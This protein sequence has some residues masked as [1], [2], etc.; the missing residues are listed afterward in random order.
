[1]GIK[2]INKLLKNRCKNGITE[3][4]ISKFANQIIFIDTSI[5]MYRYKHSGNLENNFLQLINKL[6]QFN[7]K[8]V[9]IFDGKPQDNK[10]VIQE[11]KSKREKANNK[12]IK[13]QEELLEEANKSGIIIVDN[14]PDTT[15]ID[16]DDL[17]ENLQ[18]IMDKIKRVQKNNIVVTYND[19]CNVK[20][21]LYSMNITFIQGK[22]ETDLI[23][24]YLTRKYKMKPLCLSYDT[25]FLAHGVNLL[26]K[27]DNR[28]GFIEYYDIDI[29]KKELGINTQEFIDM[30]VLMGCDYCK[31]LK[32]I[33]PMT[34]YKL[35]KKYKTLN[36]YFKSIDKKDIE[37]YIKARDT[38]INPGEL[39]IE[40]PDIE[41]K[42]INKNEFKEVCEELNINERVRNNVIKTTGNKYNPITKYF[43]V[44]K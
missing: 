10:I 37:Q 24:P 42:Q 3:I 8:P 4:S 41:I 5:F 6:L 11:R 1:M 32:G 26:S 28:S 22:C 35:I 19:F 21:I 16:E 15:N 14:I 25:D 2:N 31:S 12:V 39:E 30:C 20:K 38:F 27:F 17:P 43:K 18:I 36:N 34:A 9:F 33:G 29:I 23:V 7:I 40:L 44:K 13:L